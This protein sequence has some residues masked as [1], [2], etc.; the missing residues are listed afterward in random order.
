MKINLIKTNGGFIPADNQAR[1]FLDKQKAG[2]YLVA[3]ITKPRNAKFHRKYFAL[4]NVGFDL[5]TPEPIDNERWGA[6]EKDFDTFRGECISRAGFYI[7][8]FSTKGE[9][10]LKAQ[11]ISFANMDEIKFSNLYDKTLNVMLK[12]APNHVTKELI[13]EAVDNIM[14]F[15]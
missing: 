1:E 11:S 6:P 12:L 13:D 5:W 15:S 2:A 4:L 8:V 14:S 7:P 9:L 3:N 10:R